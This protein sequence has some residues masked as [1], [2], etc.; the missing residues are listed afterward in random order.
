MSDGIVNNEILSYYDML[1]LKNFDSSSSSD[2]ISTNSTIKNDNDIDKNIKSFDLKLYVCFG[3]KYGACNAD[4]ITFDKKT[5]EKIQ[6]VKYSY[7]ITV[8]FIFNTIKSAKSSVVILNELSSYDTLLSLVITDEPVHKV[9]SKHCEIMTVQIG[10]HM[11]YFVEFAQKDEH[12]N[13]FK[14]IYIRQGKNIKLILTY[15]RTIN[16]QIGSKL[17]NTFGQKNVISAISD[18]SE[19]W[20]ITKDGRKV[21]AQIIYDHISIFSKETA[22]QLYYMLRSPDVAFGENLILAPMDLFIHTLTPVTNLK[23]SILK[24]DTY[25]N[26]T[27]FDTQLLSTFSRTLRQNSNNSEFILDKVAAYINLHGYTLDFENSKAL[28]LDI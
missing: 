4:G 16:L 21:H 9:N 8:D 10:K 14:K 6:G 28:I 22:G 27:G 15:D 3:N 20:G 17:A 18:L 23:L 11:F 25:T 1:Y 24:N 19:Y 12:F 2:S 26:I 5:I 7:C 13:N